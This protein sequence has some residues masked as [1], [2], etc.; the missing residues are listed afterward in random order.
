MLNYDPELFGAIMTAGIL[1]MTRPRSTRPGPLPEAEGEAVQ[2]AVAQP[3]GST[4]P[5]WRGLGVVRADIGIG[6]VRVARQPEPDC[7]LA[8]HPRICGDRRLCGAR[9]SGI[10]MGVLVTGTLTLCVRGSEGETCR[11]GSNLHLRNRRSGSLQVVQV[12][13]SVPS[14]EK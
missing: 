12:Q 8:C 2:R 3:S 13:I 14:T 1:P 6:S 5:S 11:A 7:R 4:D 10:S 9:P